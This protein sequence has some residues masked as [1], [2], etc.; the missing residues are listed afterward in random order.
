MDHQEFKSLFHAP[1]SRGARAFLRSMA[2]LFGLALIL[3]LAAVLWEGYALMV[4]QYPRSW[5]E[6]LLGGLLPLFLGCC[7]LLAIRAWRGRFQELVGVR[8]MYL[9]AAFLTLAFA[10]FHLCIEGRFFSEDWVAAAIGIPTLVVGGIQAVILRRWDRWVRRLKLGLCPICG[11]DLRA[12][13]DRCPECGT[14]IAAAA[15]QPDGPQGRRE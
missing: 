15:A 5:E 12:S 3:P 14:P 1:Q 2:A 7:I 13:R 4:G 11:Y 10:L 9:A 6:L 8:G